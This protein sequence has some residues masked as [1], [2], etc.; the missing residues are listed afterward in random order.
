[1]VTVELLRTIAVTVVGAAVKV[2]CFV[3][4]FFAQR[5]EKGALTVWF[6]VTVP[7]T[8]TVAASAVLLTKSLAS[9]SAAL[10]ARI[11]ANRFLMLA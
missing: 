3:V 11:S 7:V 9:I 6:T 8:V 4:S 5:Y 2:F 1:M 10:L